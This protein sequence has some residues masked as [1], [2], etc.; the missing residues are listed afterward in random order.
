[1][2]SQSVA[3]RT[4][5]PIPGI[6]PI[7]AEEVD[8]DDNDD[9]EGDAD[10]AGEAQRQPAERVRS[11]GSMQLPSPVHESPPPQQAESMEPFLLVEEEDDAEDADW[12]GDTGTT[13]G[14]SASDVG[15]EQE[16]DNSPMDTDA[17]S[18]EAKEQERMQAAVAALKSAWAA[19]CT[20]EEPAHCVDET[21]YS[22]AEMTGFWQ[23][24]VSP[25]N[26]GN[27][28]R[29]V[30]W[31][32]LLAGG[33]G[34]P[35]KLGI[36]RS[37]SRFQ[38]TGRDIDRRWDVDSFV[39]R[40]TTLAVHR[41]GFDLAYRPPYSRRITQN[42]RIRINGHPVHKLKQLRLGVGLAAYGFR[43]ECHVFFPHMAVKAKGETHLSDKEQA[44]W[45]DNI[46]LPALRR[47]CGQRRDVYQHHPH[48]F[49]DAKSKAEVKQEVCTSGTG[50]TM[51]IKYTVPEDC[52]HSFWT[53]VLR[54]SHAHDGDGNVVPHNAFQDPFL[55]ISGHGL[56]LSSKRDTFE[57]ARRT[58]WP[59]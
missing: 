8:G 50:Y 22:L 32:P 12:I 16:T 56:K 46:V 26:D 24:Q 29:N 28:F 19:H 33:E 41:G 39:A 58:F 51:D 25:N 21:G 44:I 11:T 42:Q 36:C 4:T 6:I 15:A 35:P 37:E 48:S 7:R 13:I 3:A 43:Y 57:L 23:R 17:G 20:C 10:R 59:I 38:G 55:V 5:P 53:E 45:I 47:S 30:P 40:I 9:D 18:R 52:L 34:D 1:S 14:D 54:L 2:R 49:A 31:R 27:D